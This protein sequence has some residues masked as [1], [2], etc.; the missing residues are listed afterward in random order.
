MYIPEILTEVSPGV[1]ER[2]EKG[3]PLSTVPGMRYEKD[4]VKILKNDFIHYSGMKKYLAKQ[5]PELFNYYKTVTAVGG[6]SPKLEAFLL[7]ASKIDVLDGFADTYKLFDS[8]FR[9]IYNI[10]SDVGIK[11][12]Q[13]QLDRPFSIPT[14][15][16]RCVTFIHFL[17]HCSNWNTVCSWIRN[18][19]N[20]ILIYGPNIAAAVDDKW[21]FFRPEDHNV[22]FTIE[23]ISEIGRQCGYLIKSLSYSD[24]MLVWMRRPDGIRKFTDVD[25]KDEILKMQAKISKL[26]ESLNCLFNYLTYKNIINADEFK[27]YLVNEFTTHSE[28]KTIRNTNLQGTVSMTYYHKESLEVIR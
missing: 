26:Q 13:R 9:A 4:A 5:L 1:Y 25:N 7:Q 14:N 22:F 24:D 11:Y 10:E 19:K 23:A 21:V 20:D 18:Q 27:A 17:E 6:G 8:R 15:P 2:K 28:K 3:N 12:I 16:D